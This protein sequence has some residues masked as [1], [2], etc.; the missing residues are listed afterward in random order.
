MSDN[1]ERV[2]VAQWILDK[3]L[4]W[5][6]AADAKVV[7]IVALDTAL[8]AAL[9]TAYASA[10]SPV[11]WASLMSLTAG[12]LLVI[13]LACAAMSLFPRVDGP[14]E[15]LVFFGQVSTKTHSDYVSALTA[16]SLDGL[17]VDIAAQIHRNA[18]IAR[19]KHG[20]V[21]KSMGWS[22]LAALPWAAA[23]Y[24]LVQ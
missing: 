17:H 11:S 2:Q 19:L 16:A 3:Q 24:L 22:F 18:E 9:A 20:W 4:A 23:I 10:K 5:I 13:S 8:F 21:R 6:T 14:K 7:A 1:F 15:S 12:V